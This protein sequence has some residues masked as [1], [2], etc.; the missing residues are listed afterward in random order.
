MARKIL[1]SLQSFRRL[2][3]GCTDDM[4]FSSS[5]FHSDCIQRV[6]KVDYHETFQPRLYLLDENSTKTWL[7][8]PYYLTEVNNR[9]DYAIKNPVHGKHMSVA[10]KSSLEFTASGLYHFK[11]N[12]VKSGYTFCDLEAYFVVFVTDEP[13]PDPAQDLVRAMTSFCFGSILLTVFL[14]NYYHPNRK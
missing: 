6:Y 11:I 3:C 1:K 2:S 13:L 12:V 10:A 7:E 14:L 4:T 8:F 9:S 5:P